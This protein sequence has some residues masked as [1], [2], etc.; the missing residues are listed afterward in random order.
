MDLVTKRLIRH[1]IEMEPHRDIPWH[2][3]GR[4]ASE[5]SVALI[6]TAAIALKADR[7]FDQNGERENPWWGDPT[8]RVIPGSARTAELEVY[9]LHIDPDPVRQD[10]NTVLP[11]Q[12][13]TELADEG[14]IGN[15]ARSH[16]SFMGYL[17]DPGVFLRD[18]LPGIINH[19]REESVDLVILVPA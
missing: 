11:L 17:L 9:H 8:Y 18:S 12:R 6:S 16:Y 7:P 3:P 5:C 1:W 14:I 4:P 15:V 10:I 19:L 2:A 13:L